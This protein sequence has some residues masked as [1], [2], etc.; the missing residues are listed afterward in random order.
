MSHVAPGSVV[1]QLGALFEGG[2]MAG[3]SDRQLL[4]R[5]A[6]GGRDPAG[7]AA[8]A[9]LV[10]R[11]GPMV[12]GVCRQLL[13]DVQHAEDAFQAVF[14]VQAQKARS[15]RD[16]NLLGNWLYGVAIRTAR[17]ARTR[18]A[19]LRRWE[20]GDAMRGTGVGSFAPAGSTAPPAARSA[21]DREQAEA[22]HG[23][24]DRLPKVFRV[25]VVRC[26]FEGLTLDEAARRLRRPAGTVH[27]RLARARDKLRRGLARRG[28]VLST[29]A[30]AAAL[31]PRLASASVSSLLCDSTTRAAI[32]FAAH[33]AV[34]GAIAGPVAAMA[35]EVLRNMLWHKLRLT[36][37]PLMLLA[38]VAAGGGLFTHSFVMGDEPA[39]EPAASKARVAPQ[40]ADRPR[41]Q[42]KPGPAT[43]GGMTVTGRVLGPDGKPAAGVP[44]DV[45]GTSRVS[46]D[47]DVERAPY[48]LLGRG[49]AD[50]DGRF[51]IEAA[52]GSSARFHAVYALAG[53][54]GPGSAFGCVKLHPDDER[55]TAEIHLPPDQVIRGRVVD[56]RGQPAAGVEVQLRWLYSKSPLPL[57]GGGRFDSPLIPRGSDVWPPTADG[58]RPWPKPVATDA[59]GRFAF[60]GVGRGLQVSLSVQ[61]PRF[62]RQEIDLL[63]GD[64]DAGKEVSQ[65][66]H[67]AKVIEGR[68]LAADTG[69][70]IPDAVIAVTA[71]FGSGSSIGIGMFTTR[72]RADDQGRFRINPHA[73]D[74]FRM[75]AIAPEG[76]PYLPGR[77]NFAWPKAAVKKEIDLTLAR[78][79]LI[80]GKV[81]EQGTGRPV[82]GATVQFIA[83]RRPGRG[84]SGDVR[85]GEDG[86]FRVAVPPGKG[87]LMVLAPTFDYV[88]EE[89][90]DG[91]LYE[92]GQPGGRRLYAH[93]IIAYEVEAGEAPHE[94]NPTLKPGRTL[95]GCVVDPAGR[96]VEDALVLIRQQI[97]P[98]RLTWPGPDLIHARAGRFEL[99][100]FDPDSAMPAYFLDAEHE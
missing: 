58:L 47:A 7:E 71:N 25:P 6:A 11:H 17:C 50:A 53:A 19:R 49:A 8:F 79:V 69:R 65:A 82:P 46:G 33:H 26:Y 75:R 92:G 37:L 39:K 98:I 35:Q 99:H 24:V 63:A 84:I 13:G 43:A 48:V 14:L 42:A 29:T 64:R 1:R 18:I 15:I 41:P 27:S 2:S 76:Q 4:E 74:Y 3:L 31:A 32:Q 90:A 56:I 62:A 59:Q 100:G 70:P 38:V 16:P 45:I 67:P 10:G 12:L 30:M 34:G 5:Y 80:R 93:D 77:S 55:P 95:R 28:V 86:S 23:E 66:L 36:T 96:V 88:P 91:L 44:V 51:R 52:R 61:D 87:Y 72:Y 97:D 20:H 57:P 85:A 68:V 78:G 21:I 9:A 94:L 40:Q 73:G 60:T 89:I 81:T 54:A 83:K 22:L